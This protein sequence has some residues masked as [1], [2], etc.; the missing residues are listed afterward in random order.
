VHY[1][2]EFLCALMNEQPMGFYPPDSLVHEAQRRGI[3]VLPPCVSASGAECDVSEGAVRMGLGYVNGVREAEVKALVAER[4]RRGPFRSIAD[5]AARAGAGA[6]ALERLAWAGACDVLVD[7]PQEERRRRAL[8]LLGVAAPGIPVVVGERVGT[9]LALPLDLHDAP[10]L[11]SLD[12]WER[13]LAD[14]GSTGVTLREHPLELMRSS[15]PA[16][17]VPS[18][19]LETARHGTP[20]QVA[21]LVV[22]RQ[23]P[24]TANGVTFMLL[25]DEYGTINLIV[26]PPVHD[27][28]RLAVRGEPLVIADGRLERREGV[29]NVLVHEVRRLDRGDLP[30]AEVRHIEP[31]CTWSSEAGEEIGDLRAVA[32]AGHSFGRRGR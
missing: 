29:I 3:C 12:V 20:V 21:G 5:L 11:R 7:A 27:R 31:R 25:E 24:A 6:D 19:E 30:G 1:G 26:P 8:W 10:G 9:Q 16:G 13:L 4:E 22:A 32:P 28:C 15:L 14:Y 23:R 18:A 17:A 2:A